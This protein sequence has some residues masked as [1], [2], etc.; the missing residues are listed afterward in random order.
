M[1]KPHSDTV[2]IYLDMRLGKVGVGCVLC[3]TV[4]DMAP[5][6]SLCKLIVVQLAG[7][8]SWTL[9]GALYNTVL[10]PMSD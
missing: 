7:G 2:S 10:S 3:V 8:F 9:G 1:V 4:T 6:K 5:C